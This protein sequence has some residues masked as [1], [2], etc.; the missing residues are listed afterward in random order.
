VRVI[1]AINDYPAATLGSGAAIARRSR[2]EL[3]LRRLDRIG[4]QFAC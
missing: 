4:G 1:V 3:N 2:R